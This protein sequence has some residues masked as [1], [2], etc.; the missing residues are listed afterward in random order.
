M[1]MRVSIYG[2]AFCL[3]LSAALADTGVNEL[4]KSQPFTV[5]ASVV[6]GCVLGSG[7]SDVTTFGSLNFG[8]ISSL[9][10][11]VSI[12]SSVGA[13]SV[14]LRCNPGLSVTLALGIGN[15]ITGSIAAGRK[16]QNA[17]TAETLLYQLYQ[18]S[19]YSTLWGDGGNGGT[20]QTLSATGS[21]QEIKVYARLFSTSILPTSGVYSDTVLLTVTY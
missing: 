4:S 6:K 20:T 14:Q 2:L 8:Q 1:A 16:L 3:P 5:N 15:H 11:N 19:N 12:V 7:V 13:G 10:S 18:D 9:S 17:T 21:T